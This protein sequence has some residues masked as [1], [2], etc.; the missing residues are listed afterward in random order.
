MPGNGSTATCLGGRCARP[1]QEAAVL[2]S[3]L[4]SLVARELAKRIRGV[5]DWTIRLQAK[6]QVA[7]PQ[8]H[9]VS[10][11]AQ[12]PLGRGEGGGGRQLPGGPRCGQVWL[13]C[14]GSD[15]TKLDAS[16]RANRGARLPQGA[17]P[18]VWSPRHLSQELA[19]RNV[20]PPSTDKA[21]VRTR[22]L[23]NLCREKLS[24]TALRYQ[25]RRTGP[26]S[27][28]GWQ[29]S[30]KQTTVTIVDYAE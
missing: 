28:G 3:E 9:P 19:K 24:T 18:I 10:L 5:D 25:N 23:T 21:G 30:S 8:R 15:T 16:N 13:T 26:P 27:G 12:S 2:A 14:R 6:R 20:V 7:R 4:I 11:S 17:G 1:L 22:Y 29:T